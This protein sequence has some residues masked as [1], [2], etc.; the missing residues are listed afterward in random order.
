MLTSIPH[1]AA[2]TTE[3]CLVPG[4]LYA[5]PGGSPALRNQDTAL[6][7]DPP[8]AGSSCGPRTRTGSAANSPAASTL[9]R[10]LTSHFNQRLLPPTPPPPPGL[11]F[12]PH[13]SRPYPTSP[14]AAS[15]SPQSAKWPT[16]SIHL[17]GSSPRCGFPATPT[18][19]AAVPRHP[20]PPTPQTE[21]S[22]RVDPSP[23]PVTVR[24]TQNFSNCPNKN[25][26]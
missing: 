1:P 9:R 7:T 14:L 15:S 16:R 12:R 17:P 4:K 10:L 5:T 25:R 23:H 22:P 11:L 26:Q 21:P 18:I 24:Y 6:P 13:P 8:D 19:Q 2:Q 3:A 20:F